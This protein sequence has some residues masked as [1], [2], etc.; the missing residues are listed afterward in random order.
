MKPQFPHQTQSEGSYFQQFCSLQKGSEPFFFVWFKNGVPLKPSPEANY[1][2]EN[3]KRF[4]TL[5]I[6]K[7]ERKDSANYSCSVSN[8]FGTDSQ[9]ILLTVEG[10][11]YFI[12]NNNYQAVYWCHENLSFENIPFD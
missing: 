9:N 2:I 10:T 6:E 8:G 12:S 1:K 4:S 5:T 11:F 3:S 7:L